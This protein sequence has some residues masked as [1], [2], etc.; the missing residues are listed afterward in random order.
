M[1]L[2]LQQQKELT[3]T[4]IRIQYPEMNEKI[5]QLV[6]QIRQDDLVLE[7]FQE[8]KQYQLPLEQVCYIETSER[9]TFIYLEKE[10]YES[11]LTIQTMEHMME[12]TTM[13]RIG[14]SLLLN[15]SMLKSLKPYPNHRIM[16]ELKNGE[17]LL[18]SRKYI[19][20]LKER[21]RKEYGA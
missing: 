18:V 5:R 3:E 8:G 6:R 17:N 12:E 11:R 1:K 16:A 15:V 20:A 9:K 14:K 2:V 10:V 13:V 19:S 7:G 21:I 4:E